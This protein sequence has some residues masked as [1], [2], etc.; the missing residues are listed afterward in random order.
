MPSAARLNV[1]T[2]PAVSAVMTPLAIEAK[3][4]SMYVFIAVISRTRRRRSAK[5]RALSMAMAA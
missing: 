2:M 5:S 1:V 3:M 4:F